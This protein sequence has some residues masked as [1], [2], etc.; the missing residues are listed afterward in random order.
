MG[1][2]CGKYKPYKHLSTKVTSVKLKCAEEFQF[3]SAVDSVSRSTGGH[4]ASPMGRSK[5]LQG[6]ALIG[7]LQSRGLGESTPLCNSL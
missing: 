2:R 3:Q 1:G 6:G 4:F 5:Q 7:R